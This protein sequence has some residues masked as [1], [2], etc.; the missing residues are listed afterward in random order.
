M[1][2]L[3]KSGRLDGEG[4]ESDKEEVPECQNPIHVSRNSQGEVATRVH[5]GAIEEDDFPGAC[6]DIF[7]ETDG[8]GMGDRAAKEGADFEKEMENLQEC[9]PLIIALDPG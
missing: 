3:K 9:D 5:V 6:V 8:D 1:A 7:D 2:G 4:R